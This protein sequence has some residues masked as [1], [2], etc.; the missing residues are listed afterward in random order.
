MGGK[1]RFEE[2]ARRIRGHEIG[3]G[4]RID[5]PFGPRLITYADLTATGRYLGFLE[6]W[7]ERLRPYYANTH[8]EVSS[9]GR[10]MTNLRED[11]RRIVHRAVNAGEDDVVLF[12]GAGAT[13]AINKLVGLLGLRISE[14]LDRA[15]GLRDRVPV[16]D[17][18]VVFVGPY[19]HHSNLLPWL[20]SI[21]DTVEIGLDERGMIDLADLTVKLEAYADR[22]LR[23]GTFSAA[24]N[25]TGVL[26]DVP[27]ISRLLH[28]H[29]AL[30]FYDYA[31]A[32]PYVPIDMQGS[33]P[34]EHADAIFLSTHKFIGGPECSGL[35]VARRELFRT[36]TPERPGGGTVDYVVGSGHDDV[37]YVRSPEE[38]E[39]GG[40]PAIMG[41]LRTGAAFLVKDLLGPEEILRHEID[42]AAQATERLARHPRIDLLGPT[43]LPRLAILSLSIHDLHHDLASALLDHLFGIQN[44]AGCACAGPYGHALLGIDRATSDRF[45]RLLQR[46][47]NGMKPGWIRISLPYYASDDD[48]EFIL[49]A[50][51]F[52]AEHGLDFVPA[53]RMSW[54]DGVWRHVDGDRPAAPG[55]ELTA[56]ALADAAADRL[57]GETEPTLSDEDL[58]AERARYFEDARRIAA[59]LRRLREA[60]P[61]EWNPPTGDPEIDALAWFRYVHTDDRP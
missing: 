28:E 54:R 48:I 57:P 52:V 44:R 9:T 39:E 60:D 2:F 55:L 38:R 11:A 30:A 32:G 18:P 59:D 10:L 6:D 4:T 3:R 23:I 50:V 58:A 51:E 53:Y 25:V 5:T 43:S 34:G 31:A 26:T 47:V 22:S 42:L 27:A 12:V 33:A 35:L 1:A 29:G 45:R 49:S 46:G 20:E 56:E 19:E 14:P 61:P 36:R 17:R 24:S 40:T 16:A 21:A 13:A 41:D 8:T 37:D 15:H 7:F